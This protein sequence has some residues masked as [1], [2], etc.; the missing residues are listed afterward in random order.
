MAKALVVNT[1][2]DLDKSAFPDFRKPGCLKLLDLG[3]EFKNKSNKEIVSYLRERQKGSRVVYRSRLLLVGSGNAGKTTLVKKLTD[4]TFVDN[5]R[6]MTDGIAMSELKVDEIEFRVYD[7][8]G[9]KEYMHTHKLFFNDNAVF[10]VVYRP[11]S[12]EEEKRDFD[13]FLEMVYDCAPNAQILLVTTFADGDT[14]KG[15]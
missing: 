1:T 10:L 9:Q 2:I 3:E 12:K 14:S 4:N 13:V 11:D 8:A 15:Q 6:Q 5:F 7:F